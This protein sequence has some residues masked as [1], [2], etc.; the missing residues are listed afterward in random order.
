MS[1]ASLRRGSILA[2]AL[3]SAGPG[4]A[5]PTHLDDASPMGERAEASA[6]A[7]PNPAASAVAGDLTDV[8]RSRAR[9]E[10]L[11]LESTER[12][13]RQGLGEAPVSVG[14]TTPLPPFPGSPVEAPDATRKGR[15]PGFAV[16]APVGGDDDNPSLAKDVAVAALK[17]VQGILPLGPSKPAERPAG[18]SGVPA[19]GVELP[20]EVASG[21]FSVRPDRPVAEPE[22]T[23]AQR[24]VDRAIRSAVEAP[25]RSNAVD[26]VID[27]V[28]LRA[29]KIGRAIV[30]HPLTWLV[31]VLIGVGQVIA[32]RA[33]RGK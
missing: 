26:P 27:D 14:G 11:T 7:A 4:R 23:S 3:A 22:I 1:S 15:P 31:V 28:F 33:G 13:V 10:A 30:S 6:V 20:M 18:T 19:E 24:E 16:Q 8:G 5:G 29:I 32:S 9:R 2:L 21:A 17:W 12:M 25:D